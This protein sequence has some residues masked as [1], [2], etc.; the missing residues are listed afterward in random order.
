MNLW[1]QRVLGRVVSLREDETTVAL[2]MFAYSFLAMT[3]HNILRPITGSNFIDVLVV[4]HALAE[5][6]VHEDAKRG[7]QHERGDAY[8]CG[9]VAH[10]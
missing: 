2:L 6:G 7:Q 10:R 9:F 1:A 4:L 3:A 8:L 5:R